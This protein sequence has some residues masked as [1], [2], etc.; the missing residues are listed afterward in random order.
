MG[1]KSGM[2]S[3]GCRTRRTRRYPPPNP[4][5]GTSRRGGDEICTSLCRPRSCAITDGQ[6]AP[7]QYNRRDVHHAGDSRTQPRDH[8]ADAARRGG[9]V[10]RG[11]VP[12]PHR[13]A[14]LD[15]SAWREIRQGQRG[16][17]L[18]AGAGARAAVGGR[19]V[20][21]VWQ[22]D[23][24]AGALPVSQSSRAWLYH[25]HVMGDTETNLGLMGANR[26][27]PGA[28]AARTARRA[29]SIASLRRSS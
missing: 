1:T 18:C 16:A 9:R 14:A 11:H 3:A 6:A 7:R 20:Y 12:E 10:S 24:A 25:N 29:T 21:H 8:G 13:S 23:A 2:F 4:R 5:S 17:H 15:A 28:R 19:A 26:D 27:R 22:L